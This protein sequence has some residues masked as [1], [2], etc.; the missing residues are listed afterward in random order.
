M[1]SPYSYSD[2]QQGGYNEECYSPDQGGSYYDSDCFDFS[3]DAQD[4]YTNENSETCAGSKHTPG[5]LPSIL[6]INPKRNC[7]VVQLHSGTTFQP[8]QAA[9]LGRGRKEKEQE[10]TD[11]TPAAD[12]RPATPPRSGPP[13]IPQPAELDSDTDAELPPAAVAPLCSGPLPESQ[14]PGL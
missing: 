3:Y 9:D 2:E 14:L 1:G 7:H 12:Q 11:F 6:E 8:P 10:S 13:E 4:H 5:T